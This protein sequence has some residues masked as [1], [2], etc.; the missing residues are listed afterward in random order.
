M[1][2]LR[3]L[4]IVTL[5]GAICFIIMKL[6]SLR[7]SDNTSSKSSKMVACEYCELYIPE[8]DAVVTELKYFCCR[9]HRETWLKNNADI[10]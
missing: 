4:L 9:E 5:L 2:S 8:D 1:A 10:T 3:I 7:E 6:F